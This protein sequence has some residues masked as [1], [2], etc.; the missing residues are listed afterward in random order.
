MDT[1]ALFKLSYGV[2][3]VCSSD[4]EKVNGQIANTIFQ[5][6]SE[7]ITVAVS[8][9]KNNY[10]H[11]I[12]EK[13]KNFSV[14]ILSE[15]TPLQFIG[16]FGFKTGREI[17]K[18]ENIKYETGTTGAPIVKDFSVAILE[19]KVVNKFDVNTHTLFI[20]ELVDAH[21]VDNNQ[22]PMT[23]AFYHEVK[24]GKTQKN[25]PTYIEEKKENP[26]KKEEK[27]QKYKCEVCGYVYDPAAG[28]P[29]NGIKP[30]TPFEQLPDDWVCPVCGASK[31]EFIKES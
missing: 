7:P 10:T 3:L 6:T 5:I 8:I 17:N 27:M 19:F 29:D 16:N 12:I 13:G 28:D 24:K 26:E 20:G 11:Q 1:K 25:A 21:I 9:N 22:Q 23:Y 4:G 30:G 31:S 14:S 18:F 15:Q 2:Y